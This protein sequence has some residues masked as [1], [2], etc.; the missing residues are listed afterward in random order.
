MF[1]NVLE[2]SSPPVLVIILSCCP[3]VHA[4]IGMFSHSVM[5]DSLP[6]PWTV[7]HQPPLFMEFSRQEY[8][9]GLLFTTAGDLPDPGIEPASFVSPALAG[10]FF[11]TLPPGKPWDRQPQCV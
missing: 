8:W 9:N 7:A 10:G 6:P 1:Q 5:S 11:T 3:S 2:A 4:G